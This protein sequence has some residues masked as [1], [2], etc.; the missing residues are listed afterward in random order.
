MA[1]YE[2][3]N[4]TTSFFSSFF[5][6]DLVQ[7][8]QGSKIAPRSIRSCR[9]RQHWL[10]TE[11]SLEIGSVTYQ[12]CIL[13]VLQDSL[14]LGS[15]F[16]EVT[17]LQ[18]LSEMA[19]QYISC[20]VRF[21]LQVFHCNPIFNKNISDAYVLFLITPI[22]SSYSSVSPSVVFFFMRCSL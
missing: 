6:V 14:Y 9:A 2:F 10:T 3:L 19:G 18:W 20:R 16:T 7:I 4:W 5:H 13:G 22:A 17:P 11:S 8:L 21:F 15:E 12:V 1:S